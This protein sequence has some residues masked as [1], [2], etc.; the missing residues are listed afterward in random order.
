MVV[1]KHWMVAFGTALLLSACGAIA[2][3]PTSTAEAPQAWPSVS[4]VEA[5][6]GVSVE[7]LE[8]SSRGIPLIL[9]AGASHSAH[10]YE[11]FAPH[12][13]DR[14]RVIGVTRRR[15]GASDA[16]EED[17]G[18]RE[19]ASDIVAVLDA[20]SIE[21]AAFMGHSFGGAELAHLA[22]HHSERVRRMVFLDGGW[23]FS[24]VYNSE[25]WW[26]P[27]PEIPMQAEDQVS[28]QAVTAYF[29]RTWGVAFS[30]N[31]ILA[32]HEFDE[33]GRLVALDPNVGSMFQDMIEPTLEPLDYSRFDA[34]TLAVRA[35][36]ESVDDL[37]GGYASYSPENQRLAEATFDRWVR[38]TGPEGERFVAEVPGAEE[39]VVSRGHHDVFNV[40]PE[41]ILPPIREFLLRGH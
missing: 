1:M 26:E 31:E 37:F 3:D 17:F 38:V 22:L 2:D 6:P 7:V 20:L 30:L 29:A 15:V 19:L 41:R 4:F 23:D 21:D 13:T 8:W 10:V 11:E 33:S 16:P 18:I 12:F 25:G 9:L 24:R 5:S 36:P 28:A 32:I 39:L 35:V 34:P 40:H 27:W 14:F